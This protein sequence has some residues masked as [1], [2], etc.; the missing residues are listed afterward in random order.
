MESKKIKQERQG[1]IE[2]GNKRK[3]I[4]KKRMERKSKERKRKE[5]EKKKR[6]ERGRKR[7]LEW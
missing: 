7:E 5:R 1:K 6:K 3:K 2:N 4:G